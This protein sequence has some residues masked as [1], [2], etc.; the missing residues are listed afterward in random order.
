MFARP[1]HPAN[2][3]LNFLLHSP[4]AR[5]PFRLLSRRP[6]L[7]QRF[8]Q[9]DDSPVASSRAAEAPSPPR[10]QPIRIP[11]TFLDTPSPVPPEPKRPRVPVVE[12]PEETPEE[13]EAASLRRAIAESLQPAPARDRDFDA[14]A[15]AAASP[16]GADS[17][18]PQ[19][20]HVPSV[21]PPS[22]EDAELAKAIQ[23]SLEEEEKKAQQRAAGH[24]ELTRM[25]HLLH[26]YGF[27]ERPITGD[28]NCLF[29]AVRLHAV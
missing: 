7:E 20:L 19:E 10:S 12:E 24:E 14:V 16:A 15:T 21:S 8:G 4:H 3:L 25:K 26:L 13:E 11:I 17:Q 29:R 1:F 9:R 22:S 27:Q 28:G 2:S 5:S 6:A 18:Q 23:L